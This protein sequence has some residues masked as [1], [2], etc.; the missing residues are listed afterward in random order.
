[1]NKTKRMDSKSRGVFK[2]KIKKSGRSSLVQGPPRV[3]KVVLSPA[4]VGVV[5][6]VRLPLQPTCLEK[7]RSLEQLLFI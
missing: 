2:K 1:V 5:P 3:W 6:C 4:K 7:R